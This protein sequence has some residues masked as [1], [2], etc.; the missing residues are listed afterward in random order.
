MLLDKIFA[1]A[2]SM[3]LLVLIVLR[4]SGVIRNVERVV[5]RAG[6]VFFAGGWLVDILKLIQR[7]L[8]IADV[9]HLSAVAIE[10]IAIAWLSYHEIKTRLFGVPR[11]SAKPR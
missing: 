7:P 5:G 3:A 6:L 8:A 11:R 10:T 2:V 4:L 9:S 1:A